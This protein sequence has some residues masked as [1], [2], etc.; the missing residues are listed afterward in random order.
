[1]HVSKNRPKNASTTTDTN[2][3]EYRR[4]SNTSCYRNKTTN[5]KKVKNKNNN[6]NPNMDKSGNCLQIV[7][8]INISHKQDLRVLNT[9]TCILGSV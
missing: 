5:I 4:Y 7:Y 6:D 9:K 8:T 3:Y 2:A 1:M